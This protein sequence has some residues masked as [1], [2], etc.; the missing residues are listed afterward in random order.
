MTANA[1][2]VF[3]EVGQSLKQVQTGAIRPR[4]IVWRKNGSSHF[5]V[6]TGGASSKGR[7]LLRRE[8]LPC[9]IPR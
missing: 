6:L 7:V 8:L 9:K 1:T 4:S 5:A 2:K 3:K